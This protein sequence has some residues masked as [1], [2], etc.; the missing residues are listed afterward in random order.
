MKSDRIALS[1]IVPGTICRV[2][3]YQATLFSSP[4]T[5]WPRHGRGNVWISVSTLKRGDL[6]F[7]LAA[8]ENYVYV[9]DEKTNTG[10]LH[11]NYLELV[12]Q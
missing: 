6:V 9:I 11:V 2:T 3:V 5:I 1:D 7:V 8:N 4:E 10:S 12:E